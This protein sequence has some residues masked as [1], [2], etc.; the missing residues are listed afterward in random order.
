MKRFLVILL[1]LFPLIT[2]SQ[3]R[4][5][6]AINLLGGLAVSNGASGYHLEASG[7]YQGKGFA[8]GV[9]TGLVS[10]PPIEFTN[11]T[12][13]GLQSKLLF[14]DGE[15]KPYGLFDFGLFNFQLISDD[16]NLRTAS[17]DLGLGIDKALRSRNGFLLDVRWRWLVDYAGE[18][19]PRRV[20]TVGVGMRF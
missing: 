17:L 11:W 8:F 4:E 6:R 3:L 9:Y 10:T 5:K 14:G 19:A 12:I 13:L 1:M 7:G 15:I 16:L 18:W 20:L 2:F